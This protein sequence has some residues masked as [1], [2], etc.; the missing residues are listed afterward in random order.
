MLCVVFHVNTKLQFANEEVDAGTRTRDSNG[1]LSR[2]R[3]TSPISIQ[4]TGLRR[5]DQR[6]GKG[7]ELPLPKNELPQGNVPPP[8]Q[9]VSGRA[10]RVVFR[11]VRLVLSGALLSSVAFYT[12]QAVDT[13]TSEQAYINGEITAL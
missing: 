6:N 3:T 13:A 1:S 2:T 12:R 11:G 7:I 9:P 8:T 10:R 5:P 4:V